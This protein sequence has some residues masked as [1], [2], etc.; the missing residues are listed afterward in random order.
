MLMK[1]PSYSC[2]YKGIYFAMCIC[3]TVTPV[4]I[5][6]PYT[7]NA[8]IIDWDVCEYCASSSE[9]SM[10]VYAYQKVP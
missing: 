7:F 4:M 6:K 10:Y 2:T 9:F 1:R 8:E 5:Q 3:V